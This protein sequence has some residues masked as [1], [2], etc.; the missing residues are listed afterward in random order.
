MAGL[1]IL[2]FVLL[3]LGFF[4]AN[5]PISAAVLAVLSLGLL[6]F[7]SNSPWVIGFSTLLTLVFLFLSYQ[8]MRAFWV[9][10]P[11]FLWFRKIAPKM[12][13]TEREALEAGS[14]WWD[15]EL[16]SGKPD[17]NRLLTTPKPAL[18]E[19]EKAFIDGP[20]EEL[21]AM[22]DDWEIQQQKDL[23]EHVWNFLR[24]KRFFSL[25]IGKEYGGL[26][27]TP[28]GNSAVVTKIA[29]CN[30][31]AAVTVM[32]PNSLGPGEL[33]REFGTKEQQDHYLPRLAS[34]EDIPCFALTG[35]SAGS[36]A[37]SM[38][39]R[40]IVCRDM[41]EGKEVIGLR[42]SWNKRYI[43]L[44]P[45]ATVLGLAFRTLDPDHLLGETEDLGIS[46]ALIP[47]NTPGVWTGNRHF[48]VGTVFMNGP[49]R[50]DNVFIPLDYIIGGRDRIG[51]G[52]RMLMHSL[53]A[54]RA[55][56][57][58]ALGTAGVKCS[59][60]YSGEYALIR[61]Q[62]GLPIA[63]FEGVEEPLARLAGEAYRVDAARL[64]TLSGLA[65]GEK[66]GVLS[67]IL[68]H[69]ATEANRRCVNDAMDI[70]G[71]KGI[72]TGPGNYLAS[73]YQSLPIAITVEGAN[74]LTR[75]L[76]IFGQGAIRNHPYLQ[77]E[78]E[79]ARED[80]SV[81]LVNRFDKVLFSHTGFVINNLARS[82]VF[83]LT[84]ARLIPSPVA[85][86]TT[87]HYYR[88]LTRLSSAFALVADAVLLSLG[89]S[90]KFREKISGRLA[91]ALSHL[92]LASAILKRFED[93]GRPPEDHALVHWGMRDSLYQAQ[94]ALIN[95]L[96]NFPNIYVG[97]LIQWLI[98]PLGRPY[99]QPSDRLGNHVARILYNPGPARE[100][101]WEGLHEPG[102]E[103]MTAKL[104]QAFEGAVA[105]APL[106]KAIR[107]QLSEE[108]NI[109]NY[110]RMADTALARQLISDTQAAQIKATYRLMKD[111]INVDDFSP[112]TRQP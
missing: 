11:F 89:G 108:L 64:L 81:D 78:M 32:V 96:R 69:Y 47:V 2:L 52:W 65:L 53:A 79:L 63:Y 3:A 55:I 101:L 25:L 40:G 10:R 31:T 17:W 102:D 43:T 82:F 5:L 67:A 30:L 34:G 44:A 92:Y 1:S 84:G 29:S 39:D 80:Y 61:K 37:A 24:E 109:D 33:L 91:D 58:P 90:F 62:F 38:P 71:G 18:R 72:I 87:A 36:D 68:K 9:S 93:T 75:S 73:M 107:K 6:V 74:I 26:D 103:R 54:G 111:V 99:R 56:S 7:D 106:E 112:V 51:Q 50:G 57:L 49:T 95:T 28:Y 27:F 12:S 4:G 104:R 88:Q 66:P 60:R 23:P 42:V 45:V 41:W 8:P 100:R 35:P 20:V 46:C 16:F 105:L 21:C 22:L 76:I 110:E 98:F 19:D 77:D 59:A 15:G 97:K 83:G 13:T 70:H 85:D 48:P 94:D 14:V 86:A